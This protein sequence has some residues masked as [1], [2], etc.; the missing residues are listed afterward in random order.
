MDIRRTILWMIFVFSAFMLWNNWQTFNGHPSLLGEQPTTAQQQNDAAP[1]SGTPQAN[2]PA[3]PAVPGAATSPAQ[4]TAAAKAPSETIQI[5]TDEFR[6][7]FDTLGAQLVH[8]E[9]R[10]HH[11]TEDGAKA[12][13]LLENS[14]T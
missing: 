7:S 6:I 2:T 11:D 13:V 9:L 8:A 1:A 3:A 4:A 12:A 5:E 10:K 14:A